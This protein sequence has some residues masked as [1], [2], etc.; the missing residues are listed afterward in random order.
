MR[1]IT[2]DIDTKDMT[3]VGFYLF[4]ACNKIKDIR[5]LTLKKSTN[6]GFHLLIWTGK[7]YSL[8]YIFKI[9]KMIGDDYYR[10]R[11]DKVRTFGRQTLFKKKWTINTKV[12]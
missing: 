7:D 1:R 6:K 8:K 12:V 5:N 11:G 3:K 4:M 10:I 9:R 2:A